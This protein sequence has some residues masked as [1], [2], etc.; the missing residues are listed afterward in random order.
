M[1]NTNNQI[2][3]NP[4]GP[5]VSGNNIVNHSEEALRQSQQTMRELMEK[6]NANIVV[7]EVVTDFE[8]DRQ[9]EIDKQKEAVRRRQEEEDAQTRQQIEEDLKK[10]EEEAE[11]E[12]AEQSN[13]LSVVKDILGRR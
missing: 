1:E 3:Q 5:T 6:I 10:K 9:K 11:K 8:D 7:G 2:P 12:K 4:S 13:I